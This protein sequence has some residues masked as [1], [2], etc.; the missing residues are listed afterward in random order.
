MVLVS[1]VGCRPEALLKPPSP[2]RVHIIV[3]G[4]ADQ[5]WDQGQEATERLLREAFDAVTTSI[6]VHTVQERRS[7]LEAAGRHGLEIVFCVGS[8]F[9]RPVLS[10][11]PRYPRTAFVL[12]HGERVEFNVARVEFLFSGAAYLGGVAAAVVGGSTVGIVDLGRN[13]ETDDIEAGF[14]QGFRCRY[15]WG[16]VEVAAGV[17]GI[18]VLPDVGVKIALTSAGPPNP[19]LLAVAEASGVRLVTVGR[20]RQDF[21]N[22]LVIAAIVAD[23]PEAI[24]RIVADVVD[25]TFTGKVYAF[26]L[27]SGVVD[28]RLNPALAGNEELEQALDQARDA[29]NA[30]MVEIEAL[31]L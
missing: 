11:A 19:G 14:E 22:N 26:D 4:D 16:R 27:G 10:V 8:G 6:R 1:W 24:R 31:G 29:V 12:D 3:G 18:Q 15:P 20:P 13:S 5:E 21:F 2:L 25:D 28:L 17:G 30:G 23:V 7:A 9:E